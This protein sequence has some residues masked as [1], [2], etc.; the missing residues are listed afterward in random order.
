VKGLP[1][2]TL[3]AGGLGVRWV[4]YPEPVPAPV[5]RHAD[6]VKLAHPALQGKLVCDLRPHDLVP[7]DVVTG[8]F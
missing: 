4:G 7:V 1:V 6:L 5:I 2:G 8:S 3:A